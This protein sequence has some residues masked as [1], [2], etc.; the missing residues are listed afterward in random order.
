MVEQGIHISN[1]PESTVALVGPVSTVPKI[2][3]R[4][5]AAISLLQ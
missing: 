2:E 4:G 3:P 5:G 1:P